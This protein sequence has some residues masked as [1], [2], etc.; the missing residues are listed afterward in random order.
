MD[1]QVCDPVL[2]NKVRRAISLGMTG[3]YEKAARFMEIV[4]LLIGDTSGRADLIDNDVI[5][6]S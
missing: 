1:G 6:R 3:A 2:C 5:N 4:R